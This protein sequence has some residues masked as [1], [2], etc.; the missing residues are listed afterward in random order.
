LGDYLPLLKKNG[1]L[2]I[3]YTLEY[4]RFGNNLTIQG[5]LKDLQILKD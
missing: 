4:N 1:K 2:D 3:A 5:K